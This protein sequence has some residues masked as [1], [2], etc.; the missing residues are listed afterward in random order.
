IVDF[1]KASEK[2]P[3]IIDNA[4][5]NRGAS[6]NGEHIFVA[7][8][9]GGNNVF[10]WDSTNPNAEP[11]KL[12]M[13]GVTG[14]TF[15]VSDVAT[16]GKHIIMSN[17]AFKDGAFKVYHWSDTKAEPKVLLQ[18][19]VAP[20][21]LGDAI[22]VI[23]DPG[24]KAQLFVSGHG[25]KNF[26]IWDI[27]AGK[28]DSVTPKVI[29]FDSL[30][31]VNFARINKVPGENSYLLSGP[32]PRLVLLNDKFEQIDRAAGE[33]V[34]SW[35]M[36]AQVFYNESRRYMSYVHIRSNP[37]ENDLHVID[38]TKGKN[39]TDAFKMMRDSS[40]TK[41]FA[42][43]INL[44][45]ISNGNASVGH[46]VVTDKKGKVWLMA[47][48]AGNGLILQRVAEEE[49]G[50][51]VVKLNPITTIVDFTKASEKLPAII[52]NA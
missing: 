49:S 40:I 9:Q 25:S 5:N 27:I 13:T 21:R 1:T 7:S 26:Y 22:S 11:G 36:H 35:P 30:P 37:V 43:T 17:M 20:A 38:I 6:F 33:F 24:T 39:M 42:H 48:A 15:T 4:G 50:V 19:P 10:F 32:N 12:D 16:A 3:A 47:Y 46:S 41:L 52:D 34:L 2:L 29:T 51:A 8:R 18:V 28:I 31:D 23:G 44:G 14:G 45:K